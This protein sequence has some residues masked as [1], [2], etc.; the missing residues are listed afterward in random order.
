MR[1]LGGADGIIGADTIDGW[2][3]LLGGVVVAGCCCCCMSFF[4][5]AYVTDIGGAT[6]SGLF[7]FTVVDDGCCCCCC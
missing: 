6:C 3:K 4:M 7:G 5:N 2:E 1:N